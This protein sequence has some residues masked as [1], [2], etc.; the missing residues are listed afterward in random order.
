MPA[1][2]PLTEGLALELSSCVLSSKL[3]DGLRSKEVP[4]V[5]GFS[6]EFPDKGGG[7]SALGKVMDA[8]ANSASRLL[9]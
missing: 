1:L 6:S 3:P 8:A 5:V 9:K 7:D 4:K 2:P